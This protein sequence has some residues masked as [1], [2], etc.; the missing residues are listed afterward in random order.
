MRSRNQIAA[1]ALTAVVGL[2]AAACGSDD[3]GATESSGEATPHGYVEG[4][5]EMPE[6]QISLAYTADG[7]NRLHLL[8]VATE[9][10][11][12]TDL[13]VEA[14]QLF[15][16][17][18]FVYAANGNRL[19]VI[20]SGGWTVDHTEHVHYYRAP[21]KNLGVL[22]AQAPITSVAGFGTVMAVGSQD[23]DVLVVDRKAMESGE[24]D[25]VG[26]LDT[27]ST[28]GFAVPYQDGLVLARG[29]DPQQPADT[30]VYADTEGSSLG[31][32]QPCQDPQGWA[33]LRNVVAVSCAQG[34]ALFTESGDVVSSEFLEYGNRGPRAGDITFRPRSNY[35]AASTPGGVWTINS[36]ARTLDWTPSAD[37]VATAVAPGKDETMLALTDADSLRTLTIGTGEQLAAADQAGTTEASTLT[38]D[39]SR[40]YLSA[41]ATSQIFE[42]DY[43]DALRTARTFVTDGAPNLMVEVGR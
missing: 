7:G 2:T 9:E 35:A 23:G 33:I 11:A 19:E 31:T 36:S 15:E 3:G 38:I 34:V 21:V 8:D 4:A 29:S 32:E 10:S 30:L 42:I 28:S 24:L 22:D 6:A 40:A 27:N 16:D 17:G 39:T 5:Q 1:V 20:D 41:P 14:G 13:S 25:E 12:A 26:T 43:A 18:R 37:P